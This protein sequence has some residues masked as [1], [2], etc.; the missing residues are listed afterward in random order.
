MILAQKI[1]GKL[2]QFLRH[3]F[4]Y[5]MNNWNPITDVWTEIAQRVTQIGNQCGLHIAPDCTSYILLNT[6]PFSLK[7][8]GTGTVYTAG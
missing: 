3:W 1:S 7:I 8:G 2:R 5:P 4:S 6:W